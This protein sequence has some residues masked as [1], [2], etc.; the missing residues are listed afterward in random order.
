[1]RVSSKVLS[2]TSLEHVLPSIP[3]RL[4]DVRE[5][6]EEKGLGGRFDAP[7]KDEGVAEEGL[8]VERAAGA[9]VLREEDAD[10]VQGVSA[11]GSG[12]AVCFDAAVDAAAVGL[13]E[14]ADVTAA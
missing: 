12:E 6:R 14:D 8:E 3:L 1:M 13:Y 5:R 9:D 7:S 11:G 2:A 10:A 4:G